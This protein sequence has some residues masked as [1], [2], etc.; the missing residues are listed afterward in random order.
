MKNILLNIDNINLYYKN[1]KLLNNLNLTIKKNETHI[2]MGP[3]GSG[4]STFAKMLAGS[5]NYNI[6]GNITFLKKNLLMMS[7]E[8]RFFNGLLLLFQNPI[9]ILGLNTYDFLNLSYNQK[10]L[11]LK[12]KELMPFDFYLKINK[13]INNFQFIPKNLTRDLNLNFS[14]GEKKQNEIL[15]LLLLNPKL[16]ILDE[17]DSGLDLDAIQLIFNKIINQLKT[18]ITFIIITHNPI[19]LNY[20]KPKY[21]HIFVNGTIK[22]TGTKN[23]IKTIIK[24]G[25]QAYL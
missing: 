6:T 12:K 9:E 2:I 11:Y 14:G 19:I 8:I 20:I 3:N 22:K 17:L 1:N 4:K 10:N 5:L 18:K 25:Y 16:A 15:Q 7:P 21:I 23:L 13:I 24:E